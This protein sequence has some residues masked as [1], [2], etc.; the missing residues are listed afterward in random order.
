VDSNVCRTRKAFSKRD[1][2][3]RKLLPVGCGWGSGCCRAEHNGNDAKERNANRKE[4]KITFG[5]V[6][7]WND[8]SLYGGTLTREDK[9]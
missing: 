7:L 1:C 5:M 3:C 4:S 2:F 6:Y 9:W 8:S